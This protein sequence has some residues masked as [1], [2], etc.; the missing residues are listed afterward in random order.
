MIP[1]GDD[2]R[3][4]PI[5]FAAF[6]AAVIGILDRLEP[7]QRNID[8]PDWIGKPNSMLETFWKSP[9]DYGEAV[10]EMIWLQLRRVETPPAELAASIPNNTYLYAYPQAREAVGASP[11]PRAVEDSAKSST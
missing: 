1:H 9:G 2:L 8:I 11:L 6:K 5:K 10:A 4:H 3:T 7:T